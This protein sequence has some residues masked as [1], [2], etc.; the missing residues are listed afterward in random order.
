MLEVSSKILK[1]TDIQNRKFILY[2]ES[3]FDCC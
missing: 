2:F 3:Q 1:Y